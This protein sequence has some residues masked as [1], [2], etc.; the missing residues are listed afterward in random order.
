MGMCGDV[1]RD[2]VGWMVVWCL[3]R[4]CCLP[5]ELCQL[6]ALLFALFTYVHTASTHVFAHHNTRALLHTI[7][8]TI[9]VG[10]WQGLVVGGSHRHAADVF[11]TTGAAQAAFQACVQPIHGAKH[12]DFQV[13]GRASR[14]VCMMRW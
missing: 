7:M 1:R 3:Q 6:R 13:L 9:R 10:M 12:G 14:G 8:H 4:M 11:R 5:C 2:G